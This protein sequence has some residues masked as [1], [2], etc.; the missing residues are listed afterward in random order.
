MTALHRL[1]CYI[2]STIDLKLVGWV[3]DVIE[4]WRLDLYSDADLASDLL[5]RKSTSGVY[6]CISGGNTRMP[7][8]ALSKKQTCVSHSTPEAELV[9]ADVSL[10][11]EGFPMLDLWKPF[12][13]VE[14]PL[15]FHEDNES[16]ISIIR[17][18]LNPTMR[19]I[20]RTHGIC[21]A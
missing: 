6:Q 21:I 2:N 10:R 11:T 20:D 12:T 4:D 18:G 7:M 14:I 9:A 19:H 1:V 16:A 5:T 15:L 8:S 3:G 17:S 13:K